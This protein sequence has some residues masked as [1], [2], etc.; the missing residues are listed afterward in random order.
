MSELNLLL[1]FQ[2]LGRRSLEL[3]QRGPADVRIFLGRQGKVTNFLTELDAASVALPVVAVSAGNLEN[4]G[5]HGWSE[6]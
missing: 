4:T 2:V 5:L 3:V 1:I 6:K